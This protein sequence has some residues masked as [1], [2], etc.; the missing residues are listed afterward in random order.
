MT[1]IRVL[2]SNFTEIV[3]RKVGETMRCFADEKPRKMRF[4]GAIFC[5]HYPCR[6]FR[7]ILNQLCYLVIGTVALLFTKIYTDGSN[8]RPTLSRQRWVYSTLF[9]SKNFICSVCNGYIAT[10]CPRRQTLRVRSA[11]VRQVEH[12]IHLHASQ[13]S[14]KC[15]LSLSAVTRGND[16]LSTCYR[17]LQCYAPE[18]DFA[19]YSRI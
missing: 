3:R 8:I 5:P 19:K 1:L 14:A 13:R 18:S 11:D 7:A 4:F 6:R 17:V 10:E 12:P 9:L 2:Y 16:K 15:L